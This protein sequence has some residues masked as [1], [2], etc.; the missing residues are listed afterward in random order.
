MS[1]DLVHTIF[2]MKVRQARSEAGL[3]LSEFAAQCE[4]SPSYMTEIEKG[5]KYPRADKIMKMGEVLGKDYDDLVSIKLGPSLA[6][7]ESTL[8]SSIVRRFPFEEFGLEAGDLIHLLT[9]K[10]DKASALLHAI[11]E[12]GRRFDLQEEDFLRAALRSYQ[13]IHENYFQELEDAALTFASEMDEE[14]GLTQNLP[15]D[16]STLERIL[17][18]KYH[19]QIDHKKIAAH[20]ALSAYRSVFVGGRKPRL[21]VNPILNARQIKFLL[22][23]ELGYQYLGLKERSLTSTPDRIDSFQ[24]IYNDFKAA[25]FGGALLMSRKPILADLEQFFG[26]ATWDPQPLLDML[27]KYDVTSE[28]LLYRFSELI[29][30][31]FGIKLHFLRLQHSEERYQLVKH[32]NMDQLVVP[33]G[34]GLR[35]HYCRRWLSVR[36]LTEAPVDGTPPTLEAPHVGIQLS[37]FLESQD[38]F[39][40]IGFARPLVLAPHVNSSIIVGFRV[41]SDL[42][43]TIKFLE[44]PAIPTAII[45]ETCERCPLTAEQCQVRAA[46]PTLLQI[47]ERTKERRLALNELT[48]ELGK[49]MEETSKV[50]THPG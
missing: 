29:P 18:E 9:R 39:L 11:L 28:M 14:Y 42:K 27:T 37:D 6:Y 24:Q 38:R 20:E 22:A 43:E 48:T 31:F 46:E 44:D 21:L 5:R 17:G 49:E 35:E 26:R 12:I 50:P 2:G 13:E 47:R 33:S 8:S 19:Y 7:L 40:C 45:H 30:Q 25:Y 41:G 1:V 15:I 16:L 4:L 23:R 10:P 3:T 36:L 34:I 32:L